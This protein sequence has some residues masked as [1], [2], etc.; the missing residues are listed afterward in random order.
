MIITFILLVLLGPRFGNAIWWLINPVRYNL[1]FNSTL[2]G[3][4]GIIFLPWTTLMYVVVFPGGINGFDWLW[5]A[6]A[7]FSDIASYGGSAYK[8]TKQAPLP[9]QPTTTA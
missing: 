9:A 1:A 6:L 7:L 3:I 5:L 8:A 2:I 4:L